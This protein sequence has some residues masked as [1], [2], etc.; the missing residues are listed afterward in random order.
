MLLSRDELLDIIVTRCS[1]AEHRDVLE[2][3]E[4]FQEEFFNNNGEI[5]DADL[6]IKFPEVVA[7]LQRDWI[8]MHRLVSRQDIISKMNYRM[9]ADE[10]AP[11]FAPNF[12]TGLRN[13][14][15]QAITMPRSTTGAQYAARFELEKKSRLFWY[16][17]APRN[18]D[19]M[20]E[21]EAAFPEEDFELPDSDAESDR[22]WA[23][24]S[25]EIAAV[26]WLAEED[27]SAAEDFFPMLDS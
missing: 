9:S 18:E 16:F 1:P 14:L 12:Q 25:G 17:R 10:A 21:I 3:L 27:R 19:A 22:R 4:A 26:R 2:E 15:S 8:Y 23:L 20:N 24:R 6:A 7:D 5:Y 13:I 11:W